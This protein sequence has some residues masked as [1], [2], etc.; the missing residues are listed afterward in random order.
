M[1]EE[2]EAAIVRREEIQRAYAE[3]TRASAGE[4][5]ELE[6]VELEAE[7]EAEVE[8]ENR[9]SENRCSSSCSKKL[10]SAVRCAMVGIFGLTAQSWRPVTLH[11]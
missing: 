9:Q 7:A 3:A 4:G 5:M 1:K 6:V 8:V 11:L 10:W 2:G